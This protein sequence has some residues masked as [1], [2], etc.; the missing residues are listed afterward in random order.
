MSLPVTFV[1]SVVPL[2]SIAV[3]PGF[4]V[5]RVADTLRLQVSGKDGNGNAIAPVGLTYASRSPAVAT[6]SSSGLVTGVAGGTA[7]LV[8][9]AQGATG[10]VLDST[11]VAVAA[12]GVAVAVP[13]AGGRAF[14]SARVGDTVV[15]RVAVDLSGVP[16]EKLGS[17]NAQLDW[18]AGV[19]RYVSST[20]VTGGFPTPTLNETATASGQLRFGAATPT[21]TAGPVIGLLD[22]KFVAAA[23]GTPPL[24][25]TVSDLSGISPTFTRMETTALVLSTSVRVQ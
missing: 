13:L 12:T 22:I 5:V 11:L 9:S 24:T 4:G 16:G 25:F 1:V 18:T 19:L 3:T 8:A 23:A 17:Y 15:V 10:P 21:G 7:V 20:A 14:G 6:V 2:V